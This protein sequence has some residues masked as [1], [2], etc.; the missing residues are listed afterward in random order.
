MLDDFNRADGSIGSNWSGWTGS[1]AIA[2]NHLDAGDGT[3]TDIYWNDAPFGADQEVYFTF[4]QVDA[5]ADE[6]D[7]L[8][9]SQSN[10]NWGEGVLEVWYD[11]PNQRVQVWT[12]EWPAEWVQHGGDISV[13]FADEQ[14]LS[15]SHQTGRRI[16]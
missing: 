3:G 8:L 12:Y 11:A 4:S 6:Q 2:S 16:S 7:L 14:V 15:A 10:S 1:Y 13:T 9:K 5:D